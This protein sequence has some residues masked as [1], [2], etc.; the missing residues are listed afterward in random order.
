MKQKIIAGAGDA[1][2]RLDKFLLSH[3]PQYS[4]AFLKEQ[5]KQGIFLI[6]G[7]KVKPSY[8][9]R[10][11]DTVALAPGFKLPEVAKLIPNPEI[12]INIIYENTDVVVIDKPAGIS[13][14][15]RQNKNLE[16][17]PRGVRNT[18]VNGLLARWPEMA[19]VGDLPSVRPGLV[20]RLDKDTSGVIIIVK[21]QAAFE[22]LKKQF[23]GHLVTKKYL[24]LVHGR[25]KEKTGEIKCFLKRSPDPTKQQVASE[26]REAISQYKAIEEFKNYSLL[27]VIPKTGR[28][29]QIRA[30]LAW[31]GHP[32]VGDQKYGSPRMGQKPTGLTRQFL[33]AA[34]LE[35]MLLDG[36]K[37]LFKAPLA[38][39]LAATLTTLDPHT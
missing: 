30:Q 36:R 9:L 20:H 13:V 38:P 17:I 35:I 16:P 15:P 12:K 29:H 28:F 1:G 39:D 23:Q 21:N 8:V 7:K 2:Q 3:F 26:G 6:G 14:H 22:W 33:H 31:L 19:N 4:R 18:L 25:L 5:I 11:G 27:E 32:V 37:R 34:E 10:Q 24:A